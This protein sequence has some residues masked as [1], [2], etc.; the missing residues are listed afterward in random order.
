MDPE[1][2]RFER[3]LR[4]AIVKFQAKTAEDRTKIYTAARNTLNQAQDRGPRDS[5]ALEAAITD[6]EASFAVPREATA[7]RRWRAGMVPAATFAL[8]ILIGATLVAYQPVE[9]VEG[10]A[11]QFAQDYQKGAPLLPDANDFLRQI[12]DSIIDKQ[13]Q[14]RSAFAASAKTFI[15]LAKFD[16]D[17]AAQMPKTLPSGTAVI[18]RADAF[19]FK[20]LMNWTL[21]G[22]A[23]IA[24]PEMIDPVRSS[25][26]IVGCPFFGIWSGNAAKW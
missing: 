6:V 20:V 5:E 2:N 12:V 19:D 8:G 26:M 4:S 17:L 9:N 15:S 21:C 11:Q 18:V 25:G 24:A 23:S 14:D 7:A 16:P 10:P 3:S 1:E 13:K 22:V